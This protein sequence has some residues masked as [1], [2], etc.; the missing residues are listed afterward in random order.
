MLVKDIMVSRNLLT[1]TEGERLASAAQ[2]MLRGRLRHLPVVR[3]DDLVGV[4]SERDILARRGRSEPTPWEDALVGAV[5]S[6]PALVAVPDQEVAQAAAH[7]AAHKIG[8]LPVVNKG[9]LVGMVTTTD[10][11]GAAV[12]E[13]FRSSTALREPVS[14]AMRQEVFSVRDD[15]P[16]MEAVDLMATCRIRHMPVVDGEGR[17]VG[18][19]SDRDV[20]SALG[21][22]A[23]AARSWPAEASRIRVSQAMTPDPIVIKA[24]APLS[25]AVSHLLSRG[26]GALPVVDGDGRLRGILSYIDVIRA[27]GVGPMLG[28]TIQ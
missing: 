13:L 14:E 20:R 26:V 12:S 8:C 5:M 23:G 11:M 10:L 16:V 3:G 24:D 18:M 21:D 6:G 22:P 28:T 7:M 1:A 25:V 27:L 4:L 15:Q 2:K 9:R 19:L 17:V